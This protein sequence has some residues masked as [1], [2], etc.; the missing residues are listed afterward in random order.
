MMSFAS[1]EKEKHC[2]YIYEAFTWGKLK[3]RPAIHYFQ[4]HKPDLV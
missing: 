4:A 3:K 2:F 1:P